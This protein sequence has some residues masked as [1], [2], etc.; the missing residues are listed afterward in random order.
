MRIS[1]RLIFLG[2]GLPEPKRLT[3]AEMVPAFQTTVED[4]AALHVIDWTRLSMRHFPESAVAEFR[5]A[6]DSIQNIRALHASAWLLYSRVPRR[7]KP[8]RKPA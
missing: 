4:S 2:I 7:E 8:I 3:E 1:K 5:R 6:I